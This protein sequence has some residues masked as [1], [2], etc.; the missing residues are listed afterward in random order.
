[1]ILG[2]IFGP[3]LL[4]VVGLLVLLF[5]GGQIPKLAKSIGQAKREFEK[6][7][8]DGSAEPP[9]QPAATASADAPKSLNAGPETSTGG[10]GTTATFI[11]A[12]PEAISDKPSDV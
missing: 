8:A 2:E 10:G 7:L 6:G 4:I 9:R 12:A 5:G 3:D 1:V 11:D